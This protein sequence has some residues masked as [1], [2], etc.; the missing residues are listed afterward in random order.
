MRLASLIVFIIPILLSGC[1]AIRSLRNEAYNDEQME[2]EKEAHQLAYGDKN[3][4]R[5]KPLPPPVTVLDK[6]IGAGHGSPIDL[7]GIRA[8]SARVNRSDFEKAAAQNEN[9]L[10][11][12]DGQSNFLFSAN[13]QRAPGDLIS[14]EVE[15]DLKRDIVRE[16]GKTVPDDER[17]A[18]AIPGYTKEKS[19]NRAVASAV[20]KTSANGTATAPAE[21]GD[22]KKTSTDVGAS[23]S[24]EPEIS[25]TPTFITGEIL[26]RFPNG[27]I[28]MRAVKRIPYGDHARTMEVTG[29]VKE[30]DIGEDGVVKSSKFFES[31]VEA[32]R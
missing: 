28:L 3:M 10:W 15:P 4:Y 2:M 5:R 20:D 19:P 24:G 16:F 18:M 17:D 14:I 32:Y 29:I 31:K 26:Q 30:S 11:K 25:D 13:K 1:G 23:R 9:S 12:D 21:E 6:N 22:A 27:N 8:K 7:S